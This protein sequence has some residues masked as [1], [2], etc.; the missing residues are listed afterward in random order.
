MTT[1][2]SAADGAR[3]LLGGGMPNKEG[4]GIM[5]IFITAHLIDIE[6]NPLRISIEK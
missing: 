1:Q 6:G 4:D 2:I 5:F 3:V